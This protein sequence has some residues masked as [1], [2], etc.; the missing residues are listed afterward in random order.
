MHRRGLLIVLDGIDGAGKATQT[1]RLVERLEQA[2]RQVATFDFPQYRGFFGQI[3]ARYLRGEFGRAATIP[4]EFVAV[5]YAADRWTSR[6]PLVRALEQGKIV[7]LNRYV[8]S[9]IAFQSARAPIR[10]RVKLRRWLATLD[11]DVFGLPHEELTL[12]LALSVDHAQQLI[13]SKEPRS[14]LRGL[15]RDEHERNRTYLNAVAAEYE[16][17]CRTEPSAHLIRCEERGQLLTIPAIHEKIW[18][19]VTP[20]ITGLSPNGLV[21]QTVTPSR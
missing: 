3:I 20:L 17:Y 9:N 13:R 10:S 11:Y 6:E 21:D 4:P 8:P 15:R 12:Y 1:A 7:V 14:H 19:V 18:A 16:R 2:G 5:L